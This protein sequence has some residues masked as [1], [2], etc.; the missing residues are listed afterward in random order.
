MFLRAAA[1]L[2]VAALSLAGLSASAGRSSPAPPLIGANYTHFSN[3]GVCSP[4]ATVSLDG[5][6]IVANFDRPGVAGI[7]RRQLAVMRVRRLTSLRLILWHQT[8]ASGSDWGVVSSASGHLSGR[9]ESNLIG[10]LSAVRAAGFA[11]LTLSFGPVGSNSPDSPVYDR[12][13]IAENWALIKSVRPLLKRYGPPSTH[14]DL[15]NEGSPN[16]ISRARSRRVDSYLAEMYR[17]YV[18]TYGNGD[19]TVSTIASQTDVDTWSRLQNLVATLQSTGLPLPNWFDVHV[20]YAG[21]EALRDLEVVDAMLSSA[22]LRQPLVVSEA[23]Y[24]DLPTAKA[25][26]RFLAMPR[27]RVLE[28]MEWPLRAGQQCRGLSVSPPFSAS[29]YIHVLAGQPRRVRM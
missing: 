4:I 21:N 22:E 25:I 17:R 19:V 9:I 20:S 7:V 28:L 26:A 27:R 12:T 29:A 18:Q 13:K 15:M 11:Q 24:D 16:S 5:T 8:D 6:G 14:I 10:Y 23:A 3:N 1:L 2:S